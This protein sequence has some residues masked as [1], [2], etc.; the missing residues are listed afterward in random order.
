MSAVKAA[1]KAA[2]SALDGQNYDEA[3]EQA[4]AVLK[5]DPKNYHAYGNERL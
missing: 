2:K 1:L 4:N 3:I 5:N